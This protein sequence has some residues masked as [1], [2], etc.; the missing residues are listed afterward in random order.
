MIEVEVGL[1]TDPTTGIDF[2][3]IDEVNQLLAN[4]AKVNRIEPIGAIT[5][6]HKDKN[7]NVNIVVTG[8]SLM[9]ELEENSK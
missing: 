2:F 3:G 1:R 6:Q 9:V 4:G 5:R 8:F 7:G